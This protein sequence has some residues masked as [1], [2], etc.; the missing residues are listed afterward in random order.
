MPSRSW[1]DEAE[2]DDLGDQHADRLAE[3]RRFGLDPADAPAEHAEAVD[4]RRMAVGSDQSIGI[5]E[6]FAVRVMVGPDALRD[7]LEIDLVADAGARRD[8]LEIVERLA[9][10]FEELIALAVAVIFELDVLLEGLG[11]AELVDHHAVVDDEVHRHQ[12]IDLLRVAAERKHRVAHRRQV[13]YGRDTGEV[14][15]QHARGTVLDLAVDAPLLQPVGHRLKVF[16]GDGLAVLEAEQILQQHLHREG[17]ASDIAERLA[18]LV[19]RIICVGLARDLKS[20][21]GAEAVLA[22]GDHR[23]PSIRW[24]SSRVGLAGNG[25]SG[26]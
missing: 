9:A 21:A 17:Q 7:M 2:S 18:R 12:R 16:A 4:H 26:S 8:H 6:R 15:H 24:S 23:C 25:K 10:P 20:R 14:L 13:D 19:Q 1:P 11:S 5:G 3:H 22:G